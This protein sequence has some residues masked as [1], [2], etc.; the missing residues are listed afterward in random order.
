M[1]RKTIKKPKQTSLCHPLRTSPSATGAGPG[2]LALDE[3]L[4]KC[5]GLVQ[6][7]K[8]QRRP[9]DLMKELKCTVYS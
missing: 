9:G 5:G 7:L 1:Q 4:A 8:K 6:Q 3:F 2:L